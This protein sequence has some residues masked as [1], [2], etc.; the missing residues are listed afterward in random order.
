MARKLRVW[1]PG[2]TY[3]ITARGN[4]RDRIFRE[5]Q[6]YQYY[7]S[8]I[9]SCKNHI[10]F[11]LHAYC[12]MPNHIHL[13]LET[14]DQPPGPII[15]YIHSRFAIRFNKRYELSGHLFQGRFHAQLVRTDD[16][17]LTVCK[18]IHLNPV[19]ANIVTKPEYYPWSSYAK[20]VNN[21]E[22]PILETKKTLTLGDSPLTR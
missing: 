1:F 19:E 15:H 21:K 11:N 18:Y 17:F 9:K 20:L 13:L 3:H 10:S 8:L 16:Y 4:R 22:D 2:A 5:T 14:K 6:D 12:L 7:L